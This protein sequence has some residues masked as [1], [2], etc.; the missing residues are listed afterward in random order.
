MRGF[1]F[2]CVFC[3]F[4]LFFSFFWRE[5]LGFENKIPGGPSCSVRRL[6]IYVCVLKREG[7]LSARGLNAMLPTR[8]ASIDGRRRWVYGRCCFV[9][10]S[11]LS[12]HI[13]IE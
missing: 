12:L 4:F 7:G 10:S 6:Y 8:Y 9:F 2:F 1:F 5:V 3:V 13:Y 11:L